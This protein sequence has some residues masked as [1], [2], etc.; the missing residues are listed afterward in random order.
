MG[1]SRRGPVCWAPAGI[2]GRSLREAHAH[3]AHGARSSPGPRPSGYGPTAHQRGRSNPGHVGGSWAESPEH[4]RSWIATD[5]G[6]IAPAVQ[7]QSQILPSQDVP[8]P[9]QHNETSI[10]GDRT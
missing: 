10:R 8:S 1:G 2:V 4:R 5:P 9:S 3:V 6:H 7:P